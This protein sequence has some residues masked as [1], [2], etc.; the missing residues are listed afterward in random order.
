M[1]TARIVAEY[2]VHTLVDQRRS[3]L[4]AVFLKI[5]I[6]DENLISVPGTDVGIEF[7]VFWRGGRRVM[8]DCNL[9]EARREREVYILDRINAVPEICISLDRECPPK[10]L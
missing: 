1:A 5:G 4:S 10:Q 3:P 2:Q 6:A 8:V 9:T 7:Y